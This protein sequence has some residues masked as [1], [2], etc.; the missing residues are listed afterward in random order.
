MAEFSIFHT[1]DGVGDGAS[2]YTSAQVIAWLRR[3]YLRDPA[4]QFVLRGYGGELAPT[5][6]SGANPSIDVASGAA[7]VYG[8][9]YE[10]DATKNIPFTRP[11][12]GT[13]GYRVVLRLDVAARTVR[14]VLLSSSDG[15]S[16]IPAATQSAGT[17]WDMT[18]ATFTCT[19]AGNIT[20]TDMRGYAQPNLAITAN[21]I[22]N[23]AVGTAQLADGAVT[24]AKLAAGAVTQA[25][26]AAGAVGTTQLADGAVTAAK[27]AAAVAGAGLTGGAGSPLAVG[28]GT[29]ISVAADTVGIANGGVGTAQ[30]ANDA[31]DDTKVGN[32]VPQFY[33]RKGG[34]ATDWSVGGL[35]DYTPGAVRI[36]AG[37]R[38]V[39]AAPGTG[40][41]S[42]TMTFPQAFSA[43]PIVFLV[44]N[45][46]RWFETQ[47]NSVTAS[48]FNYDYGNTYTSGGT[49]TIRLYWLAI[50]PE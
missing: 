39:T 46:P 8:H 50:G 11:T 26:L 36:Q 14:L 24:A 5:A 22:V 48:G 33:R 2:P 38:E 45:N 6:N 29:G 34:H 28:A 4:T 44:S 17:I 16:A 27:L 31:V 40:A 42:Q 3:T 32:R 20:L 15:V 25:K 18:V 9:P 43:P 1:T 37:V 47:I 35:N 49:S 7:V 12:I 30:L 10:N 23:G 13:T 41:L 19:T 21:Q